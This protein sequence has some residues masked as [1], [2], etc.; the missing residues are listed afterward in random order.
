VRQ[1]QRLYAHAR[2]R[3]GGFGASVATADN[4]DIV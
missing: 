1:Q 2:C 4:D 3:Q